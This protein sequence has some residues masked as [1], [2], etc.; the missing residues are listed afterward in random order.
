M[1]K[2]KKRSAPI[3]KK[4]KKR[5]VEKVA[6]HPLADLLRRLLAVIDQ[7]DECCTKAKG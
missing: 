2:T 7:P 6:A 3:I 1:A 5:V 4:P